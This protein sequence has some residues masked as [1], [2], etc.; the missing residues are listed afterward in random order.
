MFSSQTKVYVKT[1]K[2]KR[3]TRTTTGE[4]QGMGDDR[5]PL[6]EQRVYARPE[7]KA[8]EARAAL[9]WV[10]AHEGKTL[11]QLVEELRALGPLAGGGA[12]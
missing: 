6:G 1:A 9:E 7:N 8:E 12:V 5:T 3:R 11:V 4:E 10:A 2:G